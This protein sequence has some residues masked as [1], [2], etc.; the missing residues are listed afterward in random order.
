MTKFQVEI[1]ETYRRTIEVE[2]EN[3]DAV[4][5]YIND[6]VTQGIIDL[7]C[8]GGDYKYNREL[9]AIEIKE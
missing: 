6:Q 5:D 1:V 3:V 4:H 7:P 2:A 9:F 8:D